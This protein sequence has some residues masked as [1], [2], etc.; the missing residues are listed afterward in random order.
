MKK[1]MSIMMAAVVAI[2]GLALTSCDDVASEMCDKD[3]WIEQDYNI[4]GQN[5]TVFF[6]YTDTNGYTPSNKDDLV[7]FV[8][9]DGE[10]AIN[11]SDAIKAGLNVFV[12]VN[13]GSDLVG[14]DIDKKVLFR[15]IPKG[16]VTVEK[17]DTD[18]ED[19]E[20]VSFIDNL[21]MSDTVW[22][23]I[24]IGQNFYKKGETAVPYIIKAKNKYEIS[25]NVKDAFKNMS[26]KKILASILVQQLTGSD[27]D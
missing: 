5:I 15:N 20:S 4:E 2:C 8:A 24:E 18:E 27:E 11:T 25:T 6:Y 10:K 12:K 9:S 3:V 19:K 7:D 16:K 21:T 1:F 14:G 23:A 22:L 26:W 17:E 13:S